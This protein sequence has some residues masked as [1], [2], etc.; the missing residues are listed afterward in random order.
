MYYFYILKCCDGTKY[1]GHTGDLRMR[2]GDHLKG[3]IKYTKHRTPVHLIYFEEFLS[4]PEAYKREMQFK[5][6][7][8][9]K[10][11][12]DKLINQFS[13]TK[14]QGLNSHSDLCLLPLHKSRAH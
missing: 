1:Y 12:I 11:T 7:R 8:T 4:R 2:L 9:R 5:N 10:E 13:Q 3:K 6:G 14:C